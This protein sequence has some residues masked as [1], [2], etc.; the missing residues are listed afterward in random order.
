M[1]KLTGQFINQNGQPLKGRAEIE[2][3]RATIDAT[4]GKQVLPRRQ[5]VPLNDQGAFD[6]ELWPNARG[7]AA[8]HYRLTVA[9]INLQ[10]SLPDE[11]EVELADVAEL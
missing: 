4:T 3:H 6:V 1:T 11:P 5:L 2:L 10:F 9:R 7:E 8:S